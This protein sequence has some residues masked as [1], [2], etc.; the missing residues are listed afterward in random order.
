MLFKDK[1]PK[2]TK[3][4]K[5]KKSDEGARGDEVD[6]NFGNHPRGFCRGLA[7]P[8]ARSDDSE[9]GTVRFTEDGKRYANR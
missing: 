8:L 5:K 6:P 4:V 9:T 1:H 3:M 2:Q 7:D